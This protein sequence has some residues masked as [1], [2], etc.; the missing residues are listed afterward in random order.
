ML[1]NRPDPP[2]QALMTQSCRFAALDH[3]MHFDLTPPCQERH[4]KSRLPIEGKI[5]YAVAK[6]WGLGGRAEVPDVEVNGRGAALL[7]TS[8]ESQD[9]AS[10]LKPS[11]F[12]LQAPNP[13]TLDQSGTPTRTHRPETVS[14]PPAAQAAFA[15]RMWPDREAVEPCRLLF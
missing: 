7:S 2:A 8:T 12:E 5:E 13:E 11:N 15:R 14:G 3:W 9:P 1:L 10:S 6:P 4:R